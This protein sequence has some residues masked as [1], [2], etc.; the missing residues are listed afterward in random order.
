[1]SHDRGCFI[2]FEDSASGCVNKDCPKLGRGKY[3][4]VAI[5]LERNRALRETIRREAEAYMKRRNSA[6]R[7]W[8]HED[9]S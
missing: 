5:T 2:C 6:L 1:M 7:F 8:L 9:V 3:D 4:P